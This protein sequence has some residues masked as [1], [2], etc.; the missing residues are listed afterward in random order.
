MSN[1][2]KKN[3][4]HDNNQNNINQNDNRSIGGTKIPVEQNQFEYYN[5]MSSLNRLMTQSAD[6]LQQTDKLREKCLT[7]SPEE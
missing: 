5:I 4:A 6:L 2:H 7:F 3:D 1:E